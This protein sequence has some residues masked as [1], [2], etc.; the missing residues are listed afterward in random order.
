MAVGRRP[1]TGQP[2]PR[3]VV[4]LLLS[5]RRLQLLSLRPRGSQSPPLPKLPPEQLLTPDL[6]PRQ[7]S[8]HVPDLGPI[9][10]PLTKVTAKPQVWPLHCQPAGCTHAL[11]DEPDLRS[12]LPGPSFTVCER[13]ASAR[14]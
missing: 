10:P 11:G 6:D 13:G 12:V 4:F 9:S 3:L 5:S 7:A 14:T 1:H 8:R 2:H